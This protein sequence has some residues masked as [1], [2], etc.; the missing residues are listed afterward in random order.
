MGSSVATIKLMYDYNRWANHRVWA[1]CEGLRQEQ[2]DRNLGHSWGSVHSLLTHLH[3]ADV[4]WFARWRGHSPQV[5]HEPAEFPTF[6]E[7]EK[8]WQK[9]ELE[10]MEFVESLTDKRLAADVNY[11]TTRGDKQSQLLGHLMLHL[12]NHN[13][14]HRG[15]LAA[16]L[17]ILNVP[18][19]EDDLLFYLRENRK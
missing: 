8:A 15:E 6:A 13:T 11:I 3:A 1:V 5:L 7:L 16:M 18:H 19:P 4:I 17:T 10:I 14:H 9:T 2:W 12:A